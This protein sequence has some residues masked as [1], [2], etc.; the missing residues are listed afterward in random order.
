M[1][2]GVVVVVIWLMIGVV[3]TAQRGYFTSKS[4]SCA[5]AGDVALTLLAGPLNYFGAN[6]KIS[7][8]LPTPSK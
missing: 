7:C 3:A 6:P 1:R 8:H 4:T 2:I 5:K